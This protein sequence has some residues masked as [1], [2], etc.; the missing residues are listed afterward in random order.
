MS[1][2]NA[3][4]FNA[5]ALKTYESIYTNSFFSIASYNSNSSHKMKSFSHA[6]EEYEFIIPYET[7]P[8]LNYDNAN[9]LGEVGYC[10]PVNPFTKHGIDLELNSSLYSI[11]IDRVHFDK[12]KEEL[13]FKDRYF[14]T[15]FLVSRDLVSAL[16]N[17]KI[18]KSLSNVEN[19]IKILIKDG[20]RDNIDNRRPANK[21]FS[22]I[23]E[24]IL[25]M[26]DNYRNPS[27]TVKDIS[28]HSCYAYTYYT[29]AFKQFMDEAPVVYLNKLRLSKAKELMKDSKLSLKEIATMSG[30]MTSSAFTESFKRIIGL[31]PKDYRKKYIEGK[32]EKK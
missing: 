15:R 30:F 3:H 12:L 1:L 28:E 25:F 32:E 18:N 14:Y 23:K 10:Y 13:G 16:S 9:Y 27:L 19:V 29:K 26:M 17:L 21:Y 7:I 22:G 2:I 11:V 24:S 31:M 8:I 6:H 20:L 4:G 5:E